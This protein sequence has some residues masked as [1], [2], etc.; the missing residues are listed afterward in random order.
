MR[1][2]EFRIQVI[3][4]YISIEYSFIYVCFYLFICLSVCL[5]IYLLLFTSKL[6][7][8]SAKL[9]RLGSELFGSKST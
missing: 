7:N 4:I 6:V 9:F 3:N 8:D 2:S 5:F 1:K